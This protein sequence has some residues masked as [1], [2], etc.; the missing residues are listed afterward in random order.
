M[1]KT[2]VYVLIDLMEAYTV[3]IETG[4]QSFDL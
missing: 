2:K 1:N 3:T 4:G